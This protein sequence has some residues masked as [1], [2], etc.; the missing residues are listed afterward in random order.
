MHNAASIEITRVAWSWVLAPVDDMTLKSG[1]SNNTALEGTGTRQSEL[2]QEQYYAGG[3][4][5]T[6]SIRCVT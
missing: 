4:F 5:C 3:G 1:H 6:T 2:S